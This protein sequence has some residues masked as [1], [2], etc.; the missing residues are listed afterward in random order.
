[1]PV[2][3]RAGRGG[4]AGF[5]AGGGLAACAI[6]GGALGKV[7]RLID[8]D[9]TYDVARAAAETGLSFR[10][11]DRRFRAAVGLSAQQFARIRRV[12][13]A[14][15]SLFAGERDLG[16]LAARA[17]HPDAATFAREF[18][19]VAGLS[20]QMLMRELDQLEY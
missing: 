20:P 1:M 13:A 14:I 7:R 2:D 16:V 5:G 9:G 19:S 4:G 6:P 11:L 18:R 12:R 10:A 8:A 15:G 3:G 17:C